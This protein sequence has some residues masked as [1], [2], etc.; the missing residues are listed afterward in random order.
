MKTLRSGWTYA[1][2][3]GVLEFVFA[4]AICGCG[5]RPPAKHAPAEEPLPAE[6]PP[7]SADEATQS[8]PSSSPAAGA[9]AAEDMPGS[10]A[11]PERELDDDR[12]ASIE[13]LSRDLDGLLSL[14]TPDCSTAPSLRDQICGLAR[15]IC[16]LS[17]DSRGDPELAERCGDARARCQRATDRV[18]AACP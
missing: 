11:A 14:S 10:M 6:R 16:A 2:S 1:K 15:K 17:D 5:A 18:G 7:A 13:L 12:F 3:A 9:G 8:A 4:M